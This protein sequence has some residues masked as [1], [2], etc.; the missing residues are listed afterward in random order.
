MVVSAPVPAKD[1]A[2]AKRVERGERRP[3]RMTGF[4]LSVGGR[5]LDVHLIDLSYEGCRISTATKLGAGERIK[6]SVPRRGVIDAEVRWAKD[7]EAGLVFG[8]EQKDTPRPKLPRK[9][10]RVPVSAEVSLRRPGQCTFRV[11]VFDASTHGCNIEFVQ[12]PRP[13][14]RVWVKFDGLEALEAEVCWV[15]KFRAGLSFLK[16]I[17]PAVFDLLLE[18]LR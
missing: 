13:Q 17:H 15:E 2:Q 3:V 9:A 6:L 8:A 14:D 1:F 10:G 4:A 16:P 12:R 5:T 11:R 18:R 7:G